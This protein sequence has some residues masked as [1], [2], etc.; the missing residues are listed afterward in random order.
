MKDCILRVNIIFHS[1]WLFIALFNLLNVYFL[2]FHYLIRAIQTY[3]I[4]TSLLKFFQIFKIFFSWDLIDTKLSYV[5][6]DLVSSILFLSQN[7]ILAIRDTIN[8]LYMIPVSFMC[9]NS[10]YKYNSIFLLFMQI[11]KI[12]YQVLIKLMLRL[13]K[14]LQRN[15]VIFIW[16]N[17]IFS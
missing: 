1:K 6:N 2:R 10:R 7:T 4:L 17:I 8:F 9:N 11:M 12:L 16:L 3:I 13:I 5:F 15:F 14:E